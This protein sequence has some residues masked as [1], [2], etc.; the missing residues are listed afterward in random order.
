MKYSLFPRGMELNFRSSM[1]QLLISSLFSCFLSECM[2][3][4][5]QT[6]PEFVEVPGLNHDSFSLC[7]ENLLRVLTSV[8]SCVKCRAV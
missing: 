7:G 3:L 2:E 8:A 6:G 1:L 4:T 5:G